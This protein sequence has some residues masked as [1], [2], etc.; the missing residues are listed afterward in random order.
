MNQIKKRIDR[1][2]QLTTPEAARPP[3]V[4]IFNG[5]IPG[6]KEAKIEEHRRK[7]PDYGGALIVLPDNGRDLDGAD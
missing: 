4:V 3:A 7:W 2:E 6:D 1:L 5:D